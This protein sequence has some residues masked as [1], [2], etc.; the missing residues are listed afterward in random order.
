MHSDM[1]EEK[2]YDL[3]TV[4]LSPRKTNPFSISLDIAHN[5]RLEQIKNQRET[6]VSKSKII[7]WALDEYLQKKGFEIIADRREKDREA[8]LRLPKTFQ[9][10]EGHAKHIKSGQT[11]ELSI[12]LETT[13]D[14]FLGKIQETQEDFLSKSKIIEWALDEYFLK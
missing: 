9:K 14:Y 10:D 11:R 1:T 6:F 4:T 8:D 3:K 5:K 7:E 13:Q 12:R 2:D